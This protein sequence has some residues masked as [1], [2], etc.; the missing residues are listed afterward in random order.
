M[1]AEADQRDD[2]ERRKR[3][4]R[5]KQQADAL[6]LLARAQY[7]VGQ[8]QPGRGLDA[9]AGGQRDRRAA[10]PRGGAGRE[11]QRARQRQQHERVVV[12][13]ADSQLE[14]HGIEPDERRGPLA[15]TPRP[16]R[17][18]GDQRSGGGARQRR[19]GLQRPQAAAEAER[20]ER[21]GPQREQRA[22]RRVL[23]WPADEGKDRVDGRFGGD[24]R[25]GIEAVQNAEPGERQVPEH[26]LG[27]QRRSEQ[28][29]Q[30]GEADRDRHSRP[31][32]L[33]DRQQHG[34]VAGAD[35]QRP[36]LK[37]A[38]A[39]LP[40]DPVQRPG[41]PPGPAA[42][43][44]GHERPRGAGRAGG[45]QPDAEHHGAQAADPDRAAGL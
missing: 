13:A 42:A 4:E 14:R 19:D 36:G 31:R 5:G 24:V 45:D 41:Q 23:K 21:I 39:E 8:H 26:V 18:A 15:R 22:V 44:S 34:R 37:A 28:H 30:L 12:R 43:A 6:A 40:A 2:G 3:R 32:Q 16:P 27:D 10:Q 17:R 35:Q 38:R 7:Q 9:H 33:C 25:I 20:R 11:R 1:H 29:P